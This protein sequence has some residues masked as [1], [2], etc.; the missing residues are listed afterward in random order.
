MSNPI[1]KVTDTLFGGSKQKSSSSSKLDPRLFNMFQG[2]FDRATGV[3]D[4]LEARQIAGLTPDFNAGA[5]VVRGTVGGAG[6]QT[7]DQAAQLAGQ[8]AGFTPQQ[9]SPGS[10]LQG[11]VQ[12]YSSPYTDQVVDSAIS[13]LDRTRQQTLQGIGDQA[14]NAGA[15]GGS[16]HGVAEAETNRGFAEEAG[17]LSSQLRDRAFQQGAGFLQSDLERAMTAQQANQQAGLQGAGLRQQGAGLLGRI[18]GQQQEQE[19]QSAQALMG[20]GETQRQLSQQEMDAIRQLPLEQQEIINQALGINPAGGSG[21]VSK[22]QSTG[23]S[24]PGLLGGFGQFV[25]NMPISP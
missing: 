10:F 18:G 6:Q 4:D 24:S 5:D 13:D 8:S 15:F 2:N 25:G 19:L 12:A 14:A 11:N 3:A 21:A 16:R 22:N 17:Q 23:S 7:T 1:D 20:V 9:V